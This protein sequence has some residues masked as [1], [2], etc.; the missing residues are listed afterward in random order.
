MIWPNLPLGR[1]HLS[2]SKKFVVS[3]SFDWLSEAWG[4]TVAKALQWAGEE[5]ASLSGEGHAVDAPCRRRRLC[6]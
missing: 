3:S 2:T 4:W 6:R 1:S 5:P